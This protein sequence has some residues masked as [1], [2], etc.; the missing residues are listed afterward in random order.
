M[1]PGAGSARAAMLGALAAV[2]VV[3]FGIAG[4]AVG[5]SDR[6]TVAQ[7]SHAR[8]TAAQDAYRSAEAASYPVAWRAGY[9]EG[10]ARGAALANAKGRRAGRVAGR[11]EAQRRAAAV[12]AAAAAQPPTATTSPCLQ[13]GGG[14]CQVAGPGATGHACPAGSVPNADGGVV[15]V[16]QSAIQQANPSNTPSVNSPQGQQLL[17]SPSCKGT[18]PPPP[19]LQGSR[20]VLTPIPMLTPST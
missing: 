5:H 3:G 18:P 7:A 12:T 20:P 8:T 6:T 10:R 9:Q 15:C 13:V 16:P 1:K 2:I 14:V 11:A 4:F 19:W 17:N